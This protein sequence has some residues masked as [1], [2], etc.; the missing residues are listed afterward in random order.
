M[1]CDDDIALMID[2]KWKD[3]WSLRQDNPLD[4]AETLVM[5]NDGYII[6]LGKKPQSYEQIQ[7]QLLQEVCVPNG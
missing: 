6:E 4:D 2:A 1:T 5:D 3:L 7:G